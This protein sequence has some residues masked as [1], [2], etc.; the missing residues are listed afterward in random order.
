MGTRASVVLDARGFCQTP[1]TAM[2]DWATP[3]ADR[4][5]TASE[6]A[7]LKT[8]TASSFEYTGSHTTT[9]NWASI[10]LNKIKNYSDG[11][12]TAKPNGSFAFAEICFTVASGTFQ[13]FHTP[14]SYDGKD[15]YQ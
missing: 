4:E 3:T 5:L 1:S 2:P 9:A 6:R 13:V 14:K 10:C 15:I 11:N 12:G 8:A 7:D